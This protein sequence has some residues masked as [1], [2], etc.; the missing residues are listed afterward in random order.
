MGEPGM[1]GGVHIQDQVA[2]PAGGAHA[3]RD[4]ADR[5]ALAVLFESILPWVNY[6]GEDGG[7]GEDADRFNANA[8]DNV[9]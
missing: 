3:V 8:Q 5:S 4:V 1:G 6:G 7:R 9:D 2:N